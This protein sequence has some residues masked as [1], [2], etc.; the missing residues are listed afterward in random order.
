MHKIF[1][2]LFFYNNVLIAG[3]EAAN[4]FD[5]RFILADRFNI[6]IT[7]GAEYASDSV[8]AFVF[9]MMKA[10]YTEDNVKS[11][12]GEI[13]RL[14]QLGKYSRENAT[15]DAVSSLID[16]IHESMLDKAREVKDFVIITEDEAKARLRESVEEL[17]CD[18]TEYTKFKY[19]VLKEYVTEY[20]NDID[21][22]VDKDT[23]INLI[24]E[25]RNAAF[26]KFIKVRDVVDF[27]YRLNASVNTGW[28]V[29]KHLS[30]TNRDRKLITAVINCTIRNIDQMFDEFT[31]CSSKHKKWQIILR[32]I[33]YKPVG[34]RER[35][36]FKYIHIKHKSRL[37]AR[38]EEAM[39]EK[40]YRRAAMFLRGSRGIEELEKRLNYIISRCESR[41]DVF[42]VISAFK[43]EDG[44]DLIRL[45]MKYEC[46]D[47]TKTPRTFVYRNGDDLI[48]HRETR[49]EV[50]RRKSVLTPEQLEFLKEALD[51][52]IARIFEGKYG[53]NKVYVS[54][55]MYKIALPIDETPCGD[56]RFFLPRGSRVK[57]YDGGK[58]RAGVEWSGIRDVEFKINVIGADGR[59]LFFCSSKRAENEKRDFLKYSEIVHDDGSGYKYY[60]FDPTAIKSAYPDAAY[61]LFSSAIPATYR[62]SGLG[63]YAGCEA[64]VEGRSMLKTVPYYREN[65]HRVSVEGNRAFFFAF[66]LK[67]GEL[68]WMNAQDRAYSSKADAIKLIG[69]YNANLAI[70]SLGK[71][72]ELMSR[73]KVQRI[74]DATFVIS[75]DDEPGINPR[76]VL[77]RPCDYYILHANL[78]KI[79]ANEMH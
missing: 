58:I 54:P 17:L 27:V 41:E 37:Y 39:S 38:F 74:P 64:V 78:D 46:Y 13:E 20:G 49:E 34:V 7:S 61:V 24:I 47:C 43:D 63:C 60:D 31:E 66:D 67:A 26:A 22:Y 59:E 51:T 71:M 18:H 36:F 8:V 16:E 45:R 62:Y 53:I 28:H 11:G 3:G 56:S 55:D 73:K 15:G 50:Q 6:R 9:E 70:M 79:C 57:L 30:F 42:S 32:N 40:D 29:Q 10:E 21:C 65:M 25:T 44:K 12:E 52:V 14:R 72:F 69:Q 4:S 48:T 68:I 35:L 5:S 19:A 33:H 77:V 2:K 23:A 76:A 75:G 1:H